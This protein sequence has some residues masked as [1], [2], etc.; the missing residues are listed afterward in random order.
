MIDATKEEMDMILAMSDADLLAQLNGCD[1]YDDEFRR[2]FIALAEERDALV[3]EAEG[4]AAIIA[5]E[6]AEVLKLREK[7]QRLRGALNFI[8]GAINWEINPSNYT[9]EEVCA[10]NSQWVEMGNTASAALEEDKT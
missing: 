7:N 3:D 6:R 4:A 1:P 9:H 2:R 10:M 5:A 8:S